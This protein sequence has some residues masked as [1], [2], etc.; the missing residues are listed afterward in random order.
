MKKQKRNKGVTLMIMVITIIIM[1]ILLA[2]VMYNVQKRNKMS[3]LDYL[4]TDLTILEGKYKGY[5]QQHHYIP[6]E[7]IYTG[8][9][10]FKVQ[11]N[12]ND[13]EKYYVVDVQKLDNVSLKT[14]GTFIINEKTLSVY[15]PSGVTIDGTTYYTLPSNSN[16]QSISLQTKSM[17]IK[18]IS[19]GSWNEEKQVNCPNLLDGMTPV[20]WTSSG[21]EIEIENVEQ[22]WDNWYDYSQQKWANA[23]TKDENGNITGYW[24]W[25]PRYEYKIQNPGT[26][27]EQEISI[28]FI[29]T[30]Q[31]TPDEGYTYIHPAFMDG[32]QNGFK[33]G[34]WDE[35]IPG[36]WVS[37]YMAGFQASTINES[38]ALTNAD[39]TVVYSDSFY[40]SY[41]EDYEYNANALSQDLSESGYNSQRI[42]YPVF[43]PLTYAYNLISVGDCYTISRKIA[44]KTS[45]YG[46]KNNE[47]DSHLMK[48]SEFGAVVYLTHSVYGT[49]RQPVTANTKNIEQLYSVTGYA[50]TTPMGT[51]ASS[52][53]N[54]SGIFDLSGCA[55]EYVSAYLASG[56]ENLEIYGQSITQYNAGKYETNST[57]YVTVYQNGN[58]GSADS[59]YS[60]YK[61]FEMSKKHGDAIYET[62]LKTTGSN[63]TV[64]YSWQSGFS[65]YPSS[66]TPFFSR[67]SCYADTSVQS[68]FG[69]YRRNG[70]PTP[71][72][73]FRAVLIGKN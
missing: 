53:K 55:Y 24:V 26:A 10:S 43:K 8:D 23:V 30:S 41:P 4:Y 61:D 70:A 73:G 56:H 60:I 46:L 68:V 65:Y 29:K 22:E 42:S 71:E 35:E 63:E 37:K 48:N 19:D 40:T 18:G 9:T 3:S 69:F 72:R 17:K 38:G 2:T 66:T 21:E 50:G 39:D 5:Y 64:N 11:M 14:S 20:Y 25:I 49:N 7:Q 13:N 58:T 67:T 47:T 31:T 34:E 33:N 45:F 52:T 28:K 15:Y 12:P 59:N 51:E 36:I 16:S 32:T 27:E 57:K 54:M 44:D 62:S 1:G 6:V